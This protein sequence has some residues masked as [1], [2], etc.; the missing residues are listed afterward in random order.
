M[1]AALIS[2]LC[3]CATLS[4]SKDEENVLRDRVVQMMDA[5][6]TGNWDLVYNYY[7][8]AFRSRTSK[9]EFTSENRILFKAYAIQK[10]EI[11][12]SGKEA[13]VEISNDISMQGFD[14]KDAPEIQQW[15]NV[16][17]KWYYKV[18]SLPV[19]IKSE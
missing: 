12:P 18:R 4:S 19:P 9:G 3:G 13:R 15:V 11:F 16:D 5:K 10:L 6:I 8:P 2:F 7:D 17:G 1:F 14:F